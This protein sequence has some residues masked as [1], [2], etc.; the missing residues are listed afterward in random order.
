MTLRLFC[1]ALDNSCA[2]ARLRHER[3]RYNR[4]GFAAARGLFLHSGPAG[5]GGSHHDEADDE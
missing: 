1:A 5:E 4:N 2:C 3:D